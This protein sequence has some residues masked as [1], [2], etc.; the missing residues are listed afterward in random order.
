MG[1][2]IGLQTLGLVLTIEGP[3]SDAC[4]EAAKNNGRGKNLVAE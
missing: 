2:E 1:F 4:I 3:R